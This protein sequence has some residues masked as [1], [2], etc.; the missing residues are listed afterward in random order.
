MLNKVELTAEQLTEIAEAVK[1]GVPFTESGM[2]INY[3]DS[4]DRFEAFNRGHDD[5]DNGKACAPETD[6]PADEPYRQSWIDG[7]TEGWQFVMLQQIPWS[8]N[9]P[10]IARYLVEHPET[11]DALEPAI[12]QLGS[13]I[14]H[15][16]D[17]IKEANRQPLDVVPQESRDLLETWRVDAEKHLSLLSGLRDAMRGEGG[18]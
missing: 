12:K 15:Y 6:A 2:H 1:D 8:P 11:V 17:W 14:P 5:A 4:E 3:G 18:Q 7:Y 9:L 13:M 10:A 16:A